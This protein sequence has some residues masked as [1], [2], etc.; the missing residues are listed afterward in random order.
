MFSCL[1]EIDA[2]FFED[3]WAIHDTGVDTHDILAHKAHESKESQRAFWKYCSVLP[4]TWSSP[5]ALRRV[6]FL[7]L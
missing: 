7:L 3:Q 1:S 6:R 2:F 5:V 4:T